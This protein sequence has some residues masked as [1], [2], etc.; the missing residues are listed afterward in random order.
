MTHRLVGHYSGDLQAYRPPGEL[1]EAR[2]GDPIGR[3]AERIGD[4]DLTE[5]AAREAEALVAGALE[6]A[7]TVP[8]PDAATARSDLYAGVA[9]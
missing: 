4:L 3:L 1:D 5:A 9:P 8:F 2:R 7:R 6:R